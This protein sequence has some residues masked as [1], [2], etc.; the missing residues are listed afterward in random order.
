PDDRY[1]HVLSWLPSGARCGCRPL[2]PIA[3]RVSRPVLA[4]VLDRGPVPGNGFV[5]F[6]NEGAPPLPGHEQTLVGQA[7]Q[8][9]PDRVAADLTAL[10]KLVLAGQLRTS[11]QLAGDDL[12]TQL[13]GDLM[14]LRRAGSHGRHPTF[15]LLDSTSGLVRSDGVGTLSLLKVPAGPRSSPTMSEVH[16][17]RWLTFGGATGPPVLVLARAPWWVIASLLSAMLLVG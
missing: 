11:R 2:I 8:R 9:E 6:S 17:A 3:G 4:Q 13:I 12:G 15:V 16:V 7:A 1:G 5:R 14:V 10:R